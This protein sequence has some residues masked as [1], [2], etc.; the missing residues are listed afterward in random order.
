MLL[1]DTERFRIIK[2]VPIIFKMRLY[3][4]IIFSESGLTVFPAHGEAQNTSELFYFQ[5]I[6]DDKQ[7]LFPTKLIRSRPNDVGQQLNL[8]IPTYQWNSRTVKLFYRHRIQYISPSP[9]HKKQEKTKWKQTNT[10][11]LC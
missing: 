2:W 11:Q 3:S 4:E 8:H 6:T 7:S 9:L 1:C 10:M 5:V